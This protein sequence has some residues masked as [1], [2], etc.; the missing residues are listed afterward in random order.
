MREVSGASLVVVAFNEPE[1]LL[2]NTIS[3]SPLDSAE[4]CVVKIPFQT[5]KCQT[6]CTVVVLCDCKLAQ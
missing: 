3:C 5:K 6:A 4:S 1:Q 2:H